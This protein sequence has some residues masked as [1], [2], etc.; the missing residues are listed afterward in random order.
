MADPACMLLSNLAR[1]EIAQERLLKHISLFINLF[2]SL[3]SNANA[4][5]DFLGGV[6]AN[7][8]MLPQGC[9]AICQSE[10]T[11]EDRLSLLAVFTEHPSV[12]RRKSVANAIK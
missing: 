12:V 2:L 8:A 11:G 3:P 6:I 4:N 10:D 9:S 1:F 7:L 5:Y